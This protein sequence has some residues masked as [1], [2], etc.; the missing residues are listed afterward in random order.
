MIKVAI[1][2]EGTYI[3]V[4]ADVIECWAIHRTPYR[5]ADNDIRGGWEFREGW[6]LT[7]VPSGYG[8]LTGVPE[9]TALT[10]LV[11]ALASEL[12]W[13]LEKEALRSSKEHSREAHAWRAKYYAE[14]DR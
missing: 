2:P 4:Q 7:H 10:L 1:P 6:S 3:D 11:D 9:E 8:L 13:S 12:D 14:A 5:R